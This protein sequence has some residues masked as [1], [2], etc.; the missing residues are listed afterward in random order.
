M[1]K[2]AILI[3]LIFSLLVSCSKE[4]K[5]LVI[6]KAENLLSDA[7]TAP[8]GYEYLEGVGSWLNAETEYK[9][10]SDEGIDTLFENNFIL[11]GGN[12]YFQ[13]KKEETKKDENGTGYYY[14]S[15]KDVY[16]Y[17]SSQTGERHFLC[18]DP[19]CTHGSF[20]D[21]RYLSLG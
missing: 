19:L 17:I 15:G 5:G 4:S 7:P 3:C 18:P 16:A 13:L 1:K 10:A 8:V 14:T 9:P 2:T 21:C 11:S 12:L 6:E 20:S